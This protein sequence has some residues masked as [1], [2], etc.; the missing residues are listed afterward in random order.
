MPL[1]LFGFTYFLDRSHIFI[2]FPSRLIQEDQWGK[3]NSKE[4]KSSKEEPDMDQT[5]YQ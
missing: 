4:G 2:Q 5:Q 3:E 1:V